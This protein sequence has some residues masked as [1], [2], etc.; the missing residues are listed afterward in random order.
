MY[1]LSRLEISSIMLITLNLIGINL[2][3]LIKNIRKQSLFDILFYPE[4]KDR[5]KSQL[6]KIIDEGVVKVAIH[7]KTAYWVLNNVIYRANLDEDG[8]IDQDLAEEIDVF[9]LS[10]KEVNNLLTIIDSISE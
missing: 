2:V 3:V 7:D 1:R 10:E 8:K 5:E 4:N 6:K 9:K